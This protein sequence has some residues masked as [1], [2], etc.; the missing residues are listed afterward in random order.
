V[1]SE[2]IFLTANIYKLKNVFDTTAGNSFKLAAQ[3][4]IFPSIKGGFQIK[5]FFG[6]K[7]L[8]QRVIAPS[9]FID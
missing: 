6:T 8:L 1:I 9:I 4:K 2:K 7:T 5:F 3:I